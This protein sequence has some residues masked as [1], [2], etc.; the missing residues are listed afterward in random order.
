MNFIRLSRAE[1]R[2]GVTTLDDEKSIVTRH[3][4]HLNGTDYRQ[5]ILY[6]TKTGKTV[7]FKGSGTYNTC[8][9]S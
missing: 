5:F 4:A 3:K 8:T 7:F 9:F 1:S 6:W 2:L